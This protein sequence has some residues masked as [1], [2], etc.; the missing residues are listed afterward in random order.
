[1]TQDASPSPPT[2]SNTP[3]APPNPLPLPPLPP[4]QLPPPPPPPRILLPP[5]PHHQR[6]VPMFPALPLLRLL[7]LVARWSWRAG[8]EEGLDVIGPVGAAGRETCGW[9]WG[10]AEAVAAV[11]AAGHV[12]VEVA[13]GDVGWAH[14]CGHAWGEAEGLG[15][16]KGVFLYADAAGEGL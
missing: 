12:W 13:A 5:P 15:A 6:S 2:P 4:T 11:T 16:G 7:L 14:A 1:L 8:C 9:R 3:L 10:T